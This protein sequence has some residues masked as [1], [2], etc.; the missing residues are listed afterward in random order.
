MAK[1]FREFKTSNEIIFYLGK[2]EKSNDKLVRKYKGKENFIF[3]TIASGSPFCVI[4]SS[5]KKIN[6]KDLKE[7]AI[8]C[9]A[10]S[11]DWRDNK[12]SVKLHL[13]K[14]KDVVKKK[15]MKTGSWN[16]R[17]KPKIIKAKRREIKKWLLSNKFN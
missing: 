16:V 2:D 9:A 12:K 17:G 5:K 3:H 7:A 15:G 4:D 8:V 11:Q 6:K 14:G 13:F 1:E 10:K